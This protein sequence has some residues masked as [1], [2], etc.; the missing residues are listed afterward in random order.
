M[1]NENRCPK[2]TSFLDG[3]SLVLYQFPSVFHEVRINENDY[4][5]LFDVRVQH[6]LYKF[7]R[8]AELTRG[9]A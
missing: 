5:D 8:S 9:K 7:G 4:L 6:T 3:R 1:Q 2:N